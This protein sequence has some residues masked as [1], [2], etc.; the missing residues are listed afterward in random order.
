MNRNKALGLKVDLHSPFK[1]F[2]LKVAPCA[3]QYGI[4]LVTKIPLRN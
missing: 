3:S 2:G 4:N 1:A